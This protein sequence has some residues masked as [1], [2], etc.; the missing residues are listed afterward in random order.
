MRTGGA[1]HAS[2]PLRRVRAGEVLVRSFSTNSRPA[3]GRPPAAAVL[4]WQHHDAHLPRT[5]P[6]TPGGMTATGATQRVPPRLTGSAPFQELRWSSHCSTGRSSTNVCTGTEAL[7]SEGPPP[8]HAFVGFQPSGSDRLDE[9]LIIQLVLVGVALGE[10][11]DRLVEPVAAPQIPGNGDGVAGAGVRP[12]QRPAADTSVEAEPGRDHRLDLD[13]ALHVAQLPPVVVAGA[14]LPLAPAQ[15]DIADGLHHPLPSNHPFAVLTV[16]ALGQRAL[17]DRPGRLLDLQEQ[18]ILLIAT[19][20]QSDEGPGADT[21]HPDH[22]AG[23]ID[24]L[25]P[26]QQPPLIVTQAGPVGTELLMEAP[27]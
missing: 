15:E 9:G 21:A 2:V 27:Q 4:G 26:L 18:R 13:R 6:F 25:E 19:L 16:T 1:K 12:G 3:C 8:S 7:A 23:H 24:Q 20:E 14:V 10:V 5:S 17:Q 22:L 11:G